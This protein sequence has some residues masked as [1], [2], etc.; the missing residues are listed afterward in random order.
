MTITKIINCT[1]CN[2]LIM[3]KNQQKTK[4]C[5]YCGKTVTVAAAVKVAQASSAMEA[6]EI[7]KKL[8]AKQGFG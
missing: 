6:S 8:K 5:P 2:G 1:K 7:L 3:A 4:T